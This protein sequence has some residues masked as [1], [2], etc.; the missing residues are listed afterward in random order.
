MSMYIKITE[1]LRNE[2]TG[3][4]AI[5]LHEPTGCSGYYCSDIILIQHDEG[6]TLSKPLKPGDYVCTKTSDVG[7]FITGGN[8]G[9]QL[10]TSA[11]EH[12]KRSFHWERTLI[13]AEE[14]EVIRTIHSV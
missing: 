7:K 10:N 4:S 5:S 6:K 1:Y 9:D 14:Y 2:V 3:S 13:S 11:G 12:T 8:V